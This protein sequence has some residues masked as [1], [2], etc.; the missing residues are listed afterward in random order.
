MEKR[1]AALQQVEGHMP[2]S[3][4]ISSMDVENS[5]TMPRH[6]PS[7]AMPISRKVKDALQER[8]ILQKLENY[9]RTKV[10]M[11]E[12]DDEISIQLVGGLQISSATDYLKRNIQNLQNLLGNQG[13]VSSSGDG[14]E[15]FSFKMISTNPIQIAYIPESCVSTFNNCRSLVLQ[16]FRGCTMKNLEDL[17][18]YLPVPEELNGM[19]IV[20]EMGLADESSLIQG[21]CR[22]INDEV[23]EVFWFQEEIK[24]KRLF[25]CNVSTSLRT[26][27]GL[28]TKITS[29]SV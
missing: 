29:L 4:M 5:P 10:C 12:K 20:L 23:K 16:K 1:T 11:I 13:N 18:A 9:F 7:E 26:C 6:L 28:S 2:G 3:S 24:C 27:G 22:M 15:D 17:R 14:V 19:Y 8:L 25:V 21:P